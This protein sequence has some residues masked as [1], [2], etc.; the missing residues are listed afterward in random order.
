MEKGLFTGKKHFPDFLCSG[1]EIQVG[2]GHKAPALNLLPLP[3]WGSGIW[4]DLEE[5]QPGSAQPQG[6]N[7][8]LKKKPKSKTQ[9]SKENLNSTKNPLKPPKIPQLPKNP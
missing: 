6:K 1:G 2:R 5:T 8:N 3:L 4:G 7:S 9:H